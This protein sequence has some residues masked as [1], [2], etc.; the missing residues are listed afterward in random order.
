MDIQTIT[1]HELGHA[2]GLR[3]LYGDADA[4]KV[5]YGFANEGVVKRD[6]T[7]SEKAGSITTPE[8]RRTRVDRRPR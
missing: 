1:T 7:D 2:L 6:L 5:M 8:R 4:A 3:D